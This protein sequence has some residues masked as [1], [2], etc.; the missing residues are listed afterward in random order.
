[1]IDTQIVELCLWLALT[2][3]K[4]PIICY[5]HCMEATGRRISETEG[6]FSKYIISKPTNSFIQTRR[7]HK[8]SKSTD[9]KVTIGI[10]G[11]LAKTASFDA[12]NS[13]NSTPPLPINDP[14]LYA[15]PK[16]QTYPQIPPRTDLGEGLKTEPE[17]NTEPVTTIEN[18][19]KNTPELIFS[20]T[21]TQQ[22][23]IIKH[24]SVNQMMT[25]TEGLNIYFSYYIHIIHF[26]M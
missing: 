10:K 18:K 4:F 25:L 9:L 15:P 23:I 24:P 21:N 13:Q 11:D 8:R 26:N 2:Q 12:G 17:T 3:S 16:P 5:R 1:M 6:I 20:D 7:K 19:N 14:V 22:E